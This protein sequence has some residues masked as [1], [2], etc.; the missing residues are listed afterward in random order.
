MYSECE[1]WERDCSHLLRSHFPN[2]RQSWEDEEIFTIIIF[3]G[4]DEMTESYQTTKY[5]A[6][7]MVGGAMDLQKQ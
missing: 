1:S 7:A 3:W 5:K 2:M 6:R 4:L